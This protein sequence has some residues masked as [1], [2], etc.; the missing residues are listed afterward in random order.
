MASWF[1]TLHGLLRKRFPQV[2]F[3]SSMRLLV[4]VATSCQSIAGTTYVDLCSNYCDQYLHRRR[5]FH[6][7][8]MSDRFTAIHNLLCKR[9]PK[10]RLLSATSR[11]L[12][13][14]RTKYVTF[15]Y[16]YLFPDPTYTFINVGLCAGWKRQAGLRPLTVFYGSRFPRLRHSVRYV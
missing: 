6:S 2:R 11:Q 9:T 16:A 7:K 8:E 1:I 3:L 13:A 15:T 12:V 14:R 5:I 10:I 4:V